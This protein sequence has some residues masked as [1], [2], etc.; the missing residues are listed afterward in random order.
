SS[1]VCSSDLHHH[2]PLEVLQRLVDALELPYGQI[3][4][5]PFALLRGHQNESQVGAH[6]EVGQHVAADDQPPELAAHFLHGEVQHL[7]QIAADGL[8]GRVEVH[9]DR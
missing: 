5:V 6:G 2:R 1:D 4:L 8:F 7:H 3:D 9:Q